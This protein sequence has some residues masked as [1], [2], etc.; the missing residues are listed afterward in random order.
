MNNASSSPSA[1]LLLRRDRRGRTYTAFVHHPPS[2]VI[3][4]APGQLRVIGVIRHSV[5]TKAQ[6]LHCVEKEGALGKCVED[7]DAARG[8]EGW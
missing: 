8:G 7:E 1:P 2:G 6:S 4:L 3:E 5:T